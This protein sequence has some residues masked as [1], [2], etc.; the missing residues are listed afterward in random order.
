MLKVWLTN[1]TD[2]R[3]NSWSMMF[4]VPP[5][6]ELAPFV[7]FDK[8]QVLDVPTPNMLTFLFYHTESKFEG[9]GTIAYFPRP[10]EYV[11]DYFEVQITRQGTR[12]GDFNGRFPWAPVLIVGSIIGVVVLASRR[13]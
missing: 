10:G 6:E 7:P 5:Y 11:I 8:A 2:T 1:F 9:S 4:P 13:R 12:I 3:F